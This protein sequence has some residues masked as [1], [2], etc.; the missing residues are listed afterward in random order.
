MT[1]RMRNGIVKR[2]NTWSYVVREHAMKLMESHH[3][4]FPSKDDAG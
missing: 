3:P 4:I 1:E 2:G